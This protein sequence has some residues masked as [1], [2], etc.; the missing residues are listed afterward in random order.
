MLAYSWEESQKTVADSYFT[1]LL[2]IVFKEPD[3]IHD[4]EHQGQRRSFGV[5]P[6]WGKELYSVIGINGLT[7]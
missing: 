3:N 4:Y 1:R 2:K 5:N 6:V 7:M